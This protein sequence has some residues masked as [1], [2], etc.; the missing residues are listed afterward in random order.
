[1]KA[2][3]KLLFFGTFIGVASFCAATECQN[4]RLNSVGNVRVRS[5]L[6][7]GY[8]HSDGVRSNHADYLILRLP[9]DKFGNFERVTAYYGNFDR[10]VAS[11]KKIREGMSDMKTACTVGLKGDVSITVIYTGA[12]SEKEEFEAETIKIRDFFLKGDL[13]CS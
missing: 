3:N 10:E 7:A 13:F 4:I 12:G 2:L 11:C 5:D 9:A 8:G 6:L 1:V